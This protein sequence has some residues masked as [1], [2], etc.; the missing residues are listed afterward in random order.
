MFGPYKEYHSN[1]QIFKVGNYDEKGKLDGPYK[2]YDAD[3]N[4]IKEA[5]F[6]NGVEA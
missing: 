6:K 2:E 3:G 5:I 4:L 1:G